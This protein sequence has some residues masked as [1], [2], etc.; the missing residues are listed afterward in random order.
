MKRIVLT[1]LALAVTSALVGIMAGSASANVFCLRSHEGN[2]KKRTSDDPLTGLCEELTA[3]GTGK[4][5]TVKIPPLLRIIAGTNEACAEVNEPGQGTWNVNN[6]IGTKVAG[7]FVR[8]L[9]VP[10][11]Q[12]GGKLLTEGTR[13]IKLQNKAPFVLKTPNLGIDIT[14][15]TSISEGATIEGSGEESQGQDKGRTT[16]SSCKTKV[17]ACNVAEPI[18]TNPLKSYLAFANTQSKIVDVYE[19]TEVPKEGTATFVTLKLSGT[20]CGLLAGSHPVTGSAVAEVI[21]ANA[22][23]QEG[24]VVFPQTPIKEV[25]HE[26]KIVTTELKTSSFESSFSG[27]YG[28]RL[29]NFPEGFAA[30]ED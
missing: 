3:R 6:C 16:Y 20:G 17:S 25:E 2:Y 24:L 27:A 7:N 8:V 22:E 21:P 14:C 19:P 29:A 1:V 10:F 5:I 26:G 11:W 30:V 15:N 4:Y 13:Q 12:A 18:T 28:A 23:G 9:R